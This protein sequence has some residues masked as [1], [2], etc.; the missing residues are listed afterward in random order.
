MRGEQSFWTVVGADADPRECLI[1][2]D[3]AVEI[4]PGGVSLEPF[5]WTGERLL[6]WADVRLEQSLAEGGL[7]I[8]SVTWTA[9]DPALELAITAFAVGE[10]RASG[11]LVRYRITNRSDRP[12]APTLFL[13]LRSFQVNPP[14]QFLNRPGGF[15]PLTRLALVGT[16]VLIEDELR[17][18]LLI[19][20][21]EVGALASA[22]GALVEDYL[23]Q[24]RL[25]GANAVEDPSAAAAGALA[26]AMQLAPGAA[27]EFVLA[28]PLH[29]GMPLPPP[30]TDPL[31]WA[32]GAEDEARARWRA[33]LAA[34]ALDL[35]PTAARVV[36]TF[37]AQLGYILVNRAGPAIQPGARAYARSW[38]RDGALTASALLRVG[39]PDVARDFCDWYA[40]YQY[41][42]GKIPCVVD[43]RGA[44]PVPEHDSSGE[45]IFLVAEC[46]RYGA[47]EAFAQRHWPRV[48]AAAAY[49]DSLRHERL[50]DYWLA[51]ERREF[52][53]LLPPSISHEGYSA[54]PMHSYWD[55][56]WAL[57]GFRDAAWLAERLGEAESARRWRQVAAEF[58]AD[59]HA[60]VLAVQARHGIDYVPGCADLGD[61]DA[62]STTIALTPVQAGE[63]LPAPA[64]TRTFE[65][66]LSFFRDRREGRADWEAYT[67]YELRNVGACVQLGWREDAHELL[68]Y[69]FADQRP[70]GWRHW[71]EVVAREARLPRFLGDM[72]HTWVGSDFLRSV[73]DMLLYYDEGREALVIGAGVPAT[74]LAEG[75]V[76]AGPLPVPGGGALSFRM[77]AQGG[78]LTIA[79]AGDCRVPP[80]GILLSPPAAGEYREASA[81]G[82]ALER[83]PGGEIIL[84]ALPAR[85]RLR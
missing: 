71:A 46:L 34:P 70:A 8:P 51:P 67:P 9:A 57:R 81:D 3:G 80:G 83:L 15:A 84:R 72:P 12:R 32:A 49:L 66:F 53:G 27:A 24:G 7:P 78:D 44:D 52:H 28:L 20:P 25:P 50:G 17:V 69:Y 11:V 48:A 73:L 29:A 5:L 39:L 26:Y 74:W 56:L 40:P 37:R 64:L 30:G 79:V 38:I 6:T 58:A 65:R 1:S 21:T 60:S 75:P 36:E 63:A 2:E 77:E 43:R 85:L 23:R 59:L 54:K 13:A 18:L 31:A 4:V 62:T 10:P 76:G 42:N 16:R 47:D 68:D 33:R 45:F 55:D 61:F 19:P 14:T 35:P 82:V 22:Q 41:A